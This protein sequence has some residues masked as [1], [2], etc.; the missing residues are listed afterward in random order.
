MTLAQKQ[1]SGIDANVCSI[2]RLLFNLESAHCHAQVM[3]ECLGSWSDFK[4][5][6]RAYLAVM[7]SSCRLLPSP[8][9]FMK[10][11]RPIFLAPWFAE[12]TRICLCNAL[13]CNG[14]VLTY[15]DTQSTKSSKGALR[16]FGV[17]AQDASE[18][19]AGRLDRLLPF[20]GQH[21][22]QGKPEQ[23]SAAY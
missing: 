13:L 12:N 16:Q 17:G 22:Q 18:Q 3:S 4:T 23:K 1:L 11:P 5:L 6:W 21:V 20:F 14:P 2:I 9:L 8:S 7:M 10:T 19:T 15:F